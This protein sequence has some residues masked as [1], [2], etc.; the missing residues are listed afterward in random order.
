MTDIQFDDAWRTAAREKACK[1][2]P[3]QG[4]QPV[5]QLMVSAHR[6]AID[7]IEQAPAIVLAATRGHSPRSRNERSY[8]TGQMAEFC[9]RGDRLRDVMRAYDLPLPVRKLKGSALSPNKWPVLFRLKRLDNSTLSQI[10]PDQSAQQQRWLRAL[11]GWLERMSRRNAGDGTLFFNWAAVAFCQISNSEVDLCSDLADFAA[12]N[13]TSF[14][15]GWTISQAQRAQEEWHLSLARRSTAAQQMAKSGVKFDTPI[16]YAPLPAALDLNGFS[17]QAL[18]S[19]EDLFVEG[20]AMRHC[21]AT[22]I[23]AVVLGQSRIYSIRDQGKRV[24]TMELRYTEVGQTR[25]DFIAADG[26]KISLNVSTPKSLALY[27]LRGPCNANPP[28]R[29]QQAANAFVALLHEGREP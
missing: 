17:F 16:D 7:Y 13:H 21:V 20:A 25:R 5:A 15:E 10:I 9:R 1:L 27:Q 3:N 29:V 23:S 12:A 2:F 14:N 6:Y 24:A 8:L 22:Y 28:K 19:G 4:L 26:R 11:D 18:Q